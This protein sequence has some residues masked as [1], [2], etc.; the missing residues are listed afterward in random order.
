MVHGE[1]IGRSQGQ[2]TT[3][4]LQGMTWIWLNIVVAVVSLAVAV[5]PIIVAILLDA[6]QSRFERDVTR[7]IEQLARGSAH[8]TLA[9]ST[10]AQA[11]LATGGTWASTTDPS[12]TEASTTEASTLCAPDLSSTPVLPDGTRMSGHWGPE[13]VR[14]LLGVNDVLAATALLAAHRATSGQHTNRLGRTQGEPSQGEP[15]PDPS[16]SL[17]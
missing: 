5:G 11:T 17:N 7:D 4:R 16:A 6:E 15:S 3:L 8:A 12:T 10:N 9:S 2:S 1:E 13:R 14:A